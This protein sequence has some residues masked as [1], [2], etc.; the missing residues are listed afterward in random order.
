MLHQKGVTGQNKNTT[1]ESE[2]HTGIFNADDSVSENGVNSFHPT[3][4]RSACLWVCV[5]VSVSCFTAKQRLCA[6]LASLVSLEQTLKHGGGMRG[7]SL[8]VLDGFL[9]VLNSVTALPDL[10]KLPG[11][12][13]CAPLPGQTRFLQTQLTHLHIVFPCVADEK[14]FRCAG[15]CFTY[16]YVILLSSDYCEILDFFFYNHENADSTTSVLVKPFTTIA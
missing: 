11:E 3:N 12:D 16:I 9:E 13:L 4:D 7:A 10:F 5:C 2:Q 6:C 8:L 15:I 14:H 1:N